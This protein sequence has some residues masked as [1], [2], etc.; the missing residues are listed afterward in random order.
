MGSQTLHELL[1]QEIQEP[2]PSAASW[3]NGGD[4]QSTLTAWFKPKVFQTKQK[5]IMVT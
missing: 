5:W 4:G 1:S 2:Q 3:I